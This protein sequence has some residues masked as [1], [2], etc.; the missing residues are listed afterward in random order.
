MRRQHALRA[1]VLAR[2][3]DAGAEQLLPMAIGGDARGERVVAVDQPLGQ[4]QPVARQVVGKRRKDLRRV[5]AHFLARIQKAAANEHVRLPLLVGGQLLHDRR[6]VRLV[7]FGE[8]PLDVLAL[9]H[10]PVELRLQRAEILGDLLRL[11]PACACRPAIVRSRE[12]PAARWR[13]WPRADRRSPARGNA[14]ASGPSSIV[15]LR[16]LV[17]RQFFNWIGILCDDRLAPAQ[18]S[19]ACGPLRL[20]IGR[21]AV[22]LRVVVLD[23]VAG[24]KILPLAVGAGPGELR[25]RRVVDGQAWR[26]GPARKQRLLP[27]RLAI[28]HRAATRA[29]RSCD[30]DARPRSTAR[31]DRRASARPDR[32]P[33]TD[34]R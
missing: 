26:S 15:D 14:P 30:T 16:L 28:R 3:H 34:C 20:R 32:P 22:R 9:R 4:A 8:P 19:I 2:E 11:A 10:E 33:T 21:P 7:F 17:E 24:G 12:S 23:R 18:A 31:R 29:H 1:E 5:G 27:D 6:L 25:R 13:R